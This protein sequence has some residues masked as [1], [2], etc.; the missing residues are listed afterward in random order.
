M[1]FVADFV[2]PVKCSMQVITLPAGVIK[3]DCVCQ[4]DSFENAT[5]FCVEPKKI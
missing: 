4:E 3:H 2:C 5:A 1:L